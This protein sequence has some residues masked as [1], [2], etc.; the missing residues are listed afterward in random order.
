M[1]VGQ[2][3]SVLQSDKVTNKTKINIIYK[4]IVKSITIYSAET[5]GLQKSKTVSLEMEFFLGEEAVASREYYIS[6]MKEY[7]KLQVKKKI[8]SALQ[9]VK[10]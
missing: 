9:T 6:E 2:L 10:Y 5:Q 1:V 3:D 7:G 8:L 4:A